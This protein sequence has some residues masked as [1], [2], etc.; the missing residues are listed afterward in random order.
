MWGQL[1]QEEESVHTVERM[2]AE[3]GNYDMQMYCSGR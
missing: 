2:V 3:T 1:E